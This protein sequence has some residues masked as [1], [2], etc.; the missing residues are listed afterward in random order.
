LL[1]RAYRF[2]D[3]PFTTLRYRDLEFH[4]DALTDSVLSG[5]VRT[6]LDNYAENLVVTRGVNPLGY[7]MSLIELVYDYFHNSAFPSNYTRN[8]RDTT[9]VVF[10]D[11]TWGW[12]QDITPYKPTDRCHVDF[13]LADSIRSLAYLTGA[14][15]L[16]IYPSRFQSIDEDL[17]D[18][19]SVH[20]DIRH[21]NSIA[22]RLPRSSDRHDLDGTGWTSPGSL[23]NTAF[24]HEFQHGLVGAMRGWQDE[25]MS[26]L[27]EVVAGTVDTTSE[28]RL[29]STFRGAWCM[30]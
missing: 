2:D 16:G 25:Q 30:S 13:Y 3:D 28:I 10:G 23:R 18:G 5:D 15:A 17:S 6:T 21:A 14:T 27:A 11:S 12:C 8:S 19:R 20:E 26:A 22:V 4:W 1:F 29:L 24:F 7:D 9:A